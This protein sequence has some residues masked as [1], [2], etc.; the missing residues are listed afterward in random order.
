[1]RTAVIGSGQSAL[2]SAALLHEAGAG[3]EV[4]ARAPSI[5]WLGELS[6]RVPPS[7][8]AG[9]VLKEVVSL[10]PTDVGGRLNGWIAAA[11][12][13]FRKV[14][15]SLHPTIS[16]RC[17][18]PAGA[19]WLRPRLVDVPISCGRS[20]VGARVDGG[21]VELSLSDGSTRTVDHVLLGTGFSI[22]VRRYPFLGS[23]VLADLELAGGYP[24]LGPGL[25]SSVAAL[26]FVGAP[27]AYSCGPVMRFVVGSWYAAPAI[28]R[29]AAG[30]PAAG[31]QVLVPARAR[32]QRTRLARS[33]PPRR[34]RGRSASGPR[35]WARGS[36]RAR[37]RRPGR[38][39]SS[40]DAP[41]RPGR[42]RS[43]ASRA[44]P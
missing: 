18:R 41:R 36:G 26:H 17:I 24:V 12:D 6:G 32:V 22:D 33:P 9:Q 44:A 35:P 7:R 40:A 30:A 2:E 39:R 19:G 3:V 25:E 4:L 14:P 1:M 34:R 43:R 23:G 29:R 31:D 8:S 27:A 13:V 5:R 38:D 15:E 10:P 42:G 37:R 20:V 21:A 28:A 11:P 16:Y